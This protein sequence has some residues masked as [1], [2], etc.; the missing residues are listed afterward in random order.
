MKTSIE[1]EAP[2]GQ[3]VGIDLHR[4]STTIVSMAEDGEVLGS[5]RFV[6]QPFELAQAMA[7]AGPEPE[8]V[9]ESTSG[10]YWAA[11]VLQELGAHGHLAHALG[12]NWGNRRVKNDV[13]DAQD[14]AAM[15]ALGRLAEGWI[16]PP[17]SESYASWCA[18]AIRSSGTGPV[19][20]PRSTG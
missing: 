11:D 8:V 19:P 2:M 1:E 4:R 20:R 14:R 6:S 10:W 18:I 9:L 3:Y 16:A 5:E 12:N 15:L 17:G 7:A 13:R